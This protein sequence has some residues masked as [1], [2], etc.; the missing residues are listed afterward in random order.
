MEKDP[1]QN[2]R[3]LRRLL[4]SVQASYGRLNL[5]IA[6]CDN[7][8]YR[9]ELIGS[10]ERELA[11]KGTSC[12]H[13]RI[14]RQQ[15][16]LKQ[17]LQDLVS[18]EPELMSVENPAIV[19][20]LGADE[21]LGIRLNE[22]KSSQE[23]FFFSVQWTREGLRDFKFPIVIWLTPTIA[24]SLAQQSPDFWSWRGWVFE[25]FKPI[26]S[27]LPV[28]K[29][30]KEPVIKDSTQ[31]GADPN[32]LQKQ[33]DEL[34]SQAPDSPLL[35]SLYNSL[36]KAYKDA[37]LYAE[38]EQPYQKA[39]ELYERQL[40]ADHPDVANSLNDLAGL[41]YLQ[42]KYE[43]AEPLLVRSLEIR[44]R[45]LGVDYPDVAN[46]LNN[47]AALYQA[48]G[49]YSEAEPLSICDRYQSGNVN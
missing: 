33:I 24:T 46:S 12:H 44:E 37:I 19:T 31:T 14:D 5:L 45:Q 13:V 15:P 6:V 32:E 29:L 25:F 40:G 48:Q 27:T 26:S 3:N 17:C 8:K 11:A 42:G 22:P 28:E 30:P 21:L 34:L 35:A 2:Q 1:S 20:V 16:S 7:W 18:Q 38:A 4:M 23:Q 49:K 39:L 47:L 41:Y 9:D 43:E 10:Y 36:G